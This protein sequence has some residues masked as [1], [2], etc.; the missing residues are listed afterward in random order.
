MSEFSQ[1]EFSPT[2]INKQV[3]RQRAYNQRW[4]ELPEGTIPLTAADPDFPIPEP[5][6]ESLVEYLRAGY[7]SYGPPAGLPE[8]RE[9]AA[10]RF[11]HRDGIELS[12]DRIVAIDSAA[13]G[14]VALARA[15]LEA[16][17]EML[18]FDPVDFLFS[19]A[20]EKAGAKTTRFAL[21]ATGEIDWN[22]FESLISPRT[23]MI[24]VCQP[25]NPLG[26][27]F[28][29]PEL[30]RIL[31][32]ARK[33]DLWILADEIWSDI[34]FSLDGHISM[35]SLEGAAE[36]TLLLQG[37]SKSFG[38]AGARIGFVALPNAQH[39][40]EFLE[41]SGA[42]YTSLGASTLSQV[43]AIAAWKHCSRWL[44]GFVA[45]LRSQ[46]DF[47]HKRISK[48]AGVSV[49]VPEA[50][51][52]LFPDISN[53]GLSAE[54][55]S[56]HLRQ[57]AKVAV[58]PGSKRWFGPGAIGHIRLSLATTRDILTDALDRIESNWPV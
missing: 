57:Y 47:A 19:H 35:L 46:R 22:K 30:R 44:D 43:A 41:K 42:A 24:G 40:T 4:A 32:L 28:T 39:V 50:T 21:T 20:A 25:H 48:L 45:H 56:E 1:N 31:E 13:S 55:L 33:Y 9:A 16:D 18:I 34:V 51:F 14:M 52:V 36:R 11:S 38:L 26:R 7:L 29:E 5:I 6:R 3:L 10:I 54:E 23:R 37:T 8:F 58:V 2:E 17:D 12:A 53:T 15:Y 27:V 49:S